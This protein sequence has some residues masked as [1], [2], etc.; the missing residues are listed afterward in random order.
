[1]TPKN[2]L[3]LCTGNSARSVLAEAILNERGG[4]RYKAFSAGSRPVG[5]VNPAALAELESRGIPTEGLA[6]KSWYRYAGRGAPAF[7]FVFTV[8]DDAAG[9][10]C[11]LW[12]GSPITVHWGIPDP[13]AVRGT[14]QE[15]SRAFG[16]AY[17]RLA[18]M[19]DGFLA[20]QAETLGRAE[21][22]KALRQLG[23]E[24]DA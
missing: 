17:E 5:R 3:F 6:S 9:E 12:R 11:P 24:P 23:L 13:A 10:S 21:L 8:C 22:K 15:V 7:D 19:I 1:M 4:S 16:R 20:L 2:V 18:A 14:D